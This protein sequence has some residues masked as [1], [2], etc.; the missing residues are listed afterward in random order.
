MAIMGELAFLPAAFDGRTI[1]SS[2]TFREIN[3]SDEMLKK[4]SPYNEVKSLVW[5]E[6]KK[7]YDQYQSRLANSLQFI[8]SWFKSGSG[9]Q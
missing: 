2:T 8:D 6:V 5:G 3:A 7:T 4:Y 9:D 1:V